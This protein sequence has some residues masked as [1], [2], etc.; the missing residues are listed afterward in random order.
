[1]DF[2]NWFD[3]RS[4]YPLGRH[5]GGTIYPGKF[6]FI[7]LFICINIWLGLMAT[8]GFVHYVMNALNLTIDIRNVCVLIGP[9][10]SSVTAIVAYPC[11]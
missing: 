8:A 9:F 5:V 4:W 6:N 1:M 10:F 7:Y 3:E 11:A 2:L